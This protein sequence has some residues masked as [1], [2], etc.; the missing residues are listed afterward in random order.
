MGALTSKPY[1]FIS[2]SW[3]LKSVESVDVFDS[4]LSAIRYDYRGSQVLRVLP[5]ININLNAG[6]I[7]DKTRFYYDAVYHQRIVNPWIR[8]SFVI[9]FLLSR[10]KRLDYFYSSSLLFPCSWV[11]ALEV[12]YYSYSILKSDVGINFLSFLGLNEGLSSIRSCLAL[13]CVAG[14]NLLSTSFFNIRSSYSF[15]LKNLD[16]VDCCVLVKN[17]IR[18]ELPLLNLK[19]RE[20]VLSGKTSVYSLGANFNFNYPIKSLGNSV[21]SLYEILAGRSFFSIQLLSY[22]APIFLFGSF[23]LT[24]LRNKF[25]FKNLL[26]NFKTTKIGVETLFFSVSQVIFSEFAL[27][28]AN[29]PFLTKDTNYHLINNDLIEFSNIFIQNSQLVANLSLPNKVITYVG[30]HGDQ[31]ATIAD[32]VLPS[33]MNVEMNEI[34]LSLELRNKFSKFVVFPTF[35]NIRTTKAINCIL[36]QLFNSLNYL[37][38]I[39]CKNNA[40][41]ET[42]KSV[43]FDEIEVSIP[44]YTD[45]LLLNSY[46]I[47]T[48]NYLSDAQ[49]RASQ[50]LTLAYNTFNSSYKNFKNEGT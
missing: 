41:Y 17:N 14:S 42:T 16:K 27:K 2:R 10:D 1:A 22:N 24:D 37:P 28:F 9:N 44:H 13:N 18:L 7:T 11:F 30:S 5:S 29:K 19:L 47:I 8:S 15:S 21:S 23:N 43:V 45:F 12:L 6:W 40:S 26:N 38:I 36:K 31:N 50:N 48:N 34:F 25:L 46:N 49:T 20:M 4:Y 32:F 33:A 35:L 39:F 3:E